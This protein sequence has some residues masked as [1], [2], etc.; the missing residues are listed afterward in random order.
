MFAFAVMRLVEKGIVDLD[1]PLYLDADPPK[2]I[3]DNPWYKLITPRLVLSHQTGLPNWAY[4]TEDG[5]LYFKFKPDTGISYSGAAFTYLTRTVENITKKSIVEI[6]QEE[7]LEA[8]NLKNT[9]FHDTDTFAQRKANGHIYNYARIEEI[10]DY[11]EMASS[12]HT[13][14]QEYAKFILAMAR[15]EGLSKEMYNLM[16]DKVVLRNE[17]IES[18][19]LCQRFFGLGWNLRDSPFFG[20]SFG[21]SGSNGD[22][23]CTSTYYEDSGNGFVVM[24]NSNTGDMLQYHLHNLLN[25]GTVQLEP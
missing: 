4:D 17:R 16:F 6:M 3:E 24:T 5:R 9:Y 20:L 2:D 10:L 13:N 25:I 1:R 18:G 7:V 11:P 19:E 23:K 8:L 14:S 15:R 22:F 12:V 21:H